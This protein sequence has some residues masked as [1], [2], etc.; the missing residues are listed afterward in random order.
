MLTC[1][2]SSALADVVVIANRTDQDVAFVVLP[3]EDKPLQF[4][5]SSGDLVTVPTVGK[6]HIAFGIGI[7][8]EQV[9]LAANTAHQFVGDGRGR[10]KLE[11]ISLNETDQTAGGTR[12]VGDRPLTKIGTIPVKILVDDDHRS[13]RRVWERQLRARIEAASDIL[14]K[15]C[16]MRLQIVAIDEWD[17]DDRINDFE[18]S[19][20]EFESEVKTS[21]GRVAIGFTSQYE[22]P[23]GP[24]HLGGTRGPLHSHIFIREWSQHITEAERLEVLVHEVGH[25]LGAAHS[26]EQ[27]SVMRPR[28]GDRKARLASFQIKFDPVNTLAMNLLCEE[29]RARGVDKIN[30]VSSPTNLR[31]RQVY[32]QLAKTFPADPAAKQF[33][34]LTSQVIVTGT[35]KVIRNVVRAAE[36]NARL[37]AAD[38]VAAGQPSRTEGDALTEI[39]VRQAAWAAQELDGENA[40]AAFLLGLGIALDDSDLLQKVPKLGPFVRAVETEKERA[41]RLRVIGKPSL[42]GRR[43]LAQHFF[44]SSLLTI[45]LGSQAAEAAGLAKEIADAHR[46]G[47]FSFADLTADKAG[48]LFAKGVMSGKLTL[49]HLASEYTPDS[50]MPSIEGLPEGLDWDRFTAQYG[51]VLDDRFLRLLK[52]VRTRLVDLPPYRALRKPPTQLQP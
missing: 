39:Y 13:A 32:G 50:Y 43:D 52:D 25:F 45:G 21:P 51:S 27:D 47:G 48:V 41:A 1:W 9:L 4:S 24:F 26:P 14:E 29:V 2:S 33:L 15:H 16:R 18:A 7:E 12:V 11:Q 10:L 20:K 49:M 44:T 38:Q 35:R 31:M 30:D 42:R 22:I 3:A 34:G 6:V 5:L 28:L 23:N 37:P 17:S 8:R 46:G 19:M 40:R 36:A